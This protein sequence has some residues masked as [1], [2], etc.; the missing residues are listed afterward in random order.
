MFGCRLRKKYISPNSSIALSPDF[1]N[2]IVKIQK[3]VQ[4]AMTE[5]EK[6]ATATLR[7][8]EATIKAEHQTYTSVENRLTKRRKI[9]VPDGKYVGCRFILG[10]SAEYERL[11]GVAQYVF[12]ENRRSMSPIFVESI[13]VLS[14]IERF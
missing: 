12:N 4:H 13:L 11:V 8:E 1:K 3:G 14:F 9:S 10:S 2:G 5:S 7:K 6:R